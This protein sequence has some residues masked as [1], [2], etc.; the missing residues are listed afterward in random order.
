MW[1]WIFKRPKPR[2]RTSTENE[3]DDLRMRG[4]ELA[5]G[6]NEVRRAVEQLEQLA[7][8]ILHSIAELKVI[9][10][11]REAETALKGFGNVKTGLN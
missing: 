7:G 3:I 8:R 4:L 9:H 2:P 10:E 11:R 1:W 6:V 5:Q